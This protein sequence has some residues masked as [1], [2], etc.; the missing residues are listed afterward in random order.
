MLAH[1]VKDK[2][3]RV[4]DNSISTPPA[5]LPVSKGDII[6]LSGP[7]GMYCSGYNADGERIYIGVT[8]NVEIM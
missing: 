7:D 8:T 1:E 2:T 3:V 4:I 5:S 6:T